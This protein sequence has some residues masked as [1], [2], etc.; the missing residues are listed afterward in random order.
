VETN[1]S[2][3]LVLSDVTMP[4]MNG[5]EVVRRALKSRDGD[6]KVIFMSGGFEGV[7]FRQTDRL[8]C[9]PLPFESLVREIRSTLADLPSAVAWEGP[10]RR[11]EP[12]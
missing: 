9:K 8:L 11:R 5:P 10:E 12:A 7:R 6:V 1:H 4:K 3:K 2:I